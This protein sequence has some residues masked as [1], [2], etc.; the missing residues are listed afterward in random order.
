[1]NRI[2]IITILICLSLFQISDAASPAKKAHAKANAL[3][4]NLV[5]FISDLHT[6]PD[7][8]QPVKLKKVVDE[9]LAMKPMPRNVIALGDLA[10]LTGR[11]REYDALKPILEPLEKAGI[12]LT[13]AMGNHDRRKEFGEA[14]PEHATKSVMEGR[15]VYVVETPFVDF[16]VMDSLQ[17]GADTTKWITPGA[18]DADQRSWL[19]TTLSQY[20]KPV[21]VCSH[22]PLNE[23]GISKLLS[24]SPSCCGYIY[25]H[26][27]R[28]RKDWIEDWG[29]SRVVRTL[30]M[31]STGHWG[32]IG[33]VTMTID[34][35]TAVA[36]LHES[37][38]F[39]PDKPVNSKDAPAQW[40][41]IS[42]EYDG[43]VCSFSLQ[44]R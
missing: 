2:K 22:H 5:V 6:N 23:T 30:C 29:P 36:T 34:K 38:F 31:P 20:E 32:D 8:H 18:I 44:T 3:D 16:I 11:P 17:E 7:G 27:H 43:D 42:D 41:M 1:M 28:W 13:L 37:D 35:D 40:K 19:E 39:F 14:F 9:I 33:Y 21:F 24:R 4:D 26:M 15:Y 12:S 10:Y 25:G